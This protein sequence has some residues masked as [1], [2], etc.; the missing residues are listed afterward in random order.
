MKY[1]FFFLSLFLCSLTHSHDPIY[2]SFNKAN[3]QNALEKLLET[4]NAVSEHQ[5]FEKNE[6]TFQDDVNIQDNHNHIENDQTDQNNSSSYKA[7]LM[8]YICTFY[9]FTSINYQTLNRANAQNSSEEL[10]EEE[11]ISQEKQKSCDHD[12]KQILF[13]QAKN[14]LYHIYTTPFEQ[15]ASLDDILLTI[16]YIFEQFDPVPTEFLTIARKILQ[17]YIDDMSEKNWQTRFIQANNA[18][19]AYIDKVG[20]E[21]CSLENILSILTHFNITARNGFDIEYNQQVTVTGEKTHNTKLLFRIIKKTPPISSS[22]V[23]FIGKIFELLP[24]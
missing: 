1:Y 13:V 12:Q 5:Y 22:D 4:E 19:I 14:L 21:N 10:L 7:T 6:E 17:Q 23:S 15:R 3:A 8:N 18:C 20:P 2:Q 9:P 11:D 16:D 24:F